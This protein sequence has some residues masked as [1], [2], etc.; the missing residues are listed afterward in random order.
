VL[1]SAPAGTGKTSLVAEWVEAA[2]HRADVTGWI[3]FEHTDTDFW[4]A[5]LECLRRLGLD[6]TAVTQGQPADAVLGTVRLTR[7]AGLVREAPHTLTIVADG[8]EMRSLEQAREVDHL[9]R[10]AAGRLRLVLVTRVDPVLPLYRYRLDE[11]LVEIRVDDLALSGEEAAGLLARFGVGL[12]EAAT[13]DLNERARGWV[14]GVRLAARTLSG[15]R[16]AEAAAA[17]FVSQTSDVNEYLLCEVLDQQ[18]PE[19]RRFLL[20]TAVPDVFSFELVEAIGGRDFV[21]TLAE[22]LRTESFMEAEPDRPGC[23]RYY[24]FFR[25]LLRAQLAYESPGRDQEVHRAVARYFAREGL[26]QQA[27]VHLATVEAWDELAPL[28]V[29]GLK[30]GTMLL[31]GT[32][33][34]LA[35]VTRKIP[36]HV[37]QR[38]A[39]LLRAALAITE[40]DPVTAGQ[41]LARA[42][43][44]SAVD[45]ARDAAV[46]VSAATLDALLACLAAPVD[47]ALEIIEEATLIL[48]SLDPHSDVPGAKELHA[49]T[50]LSCG[51][52]RLRQGALLDARRKL[53]GI[54]GSAVGDSYLTLKS[55]CLAYLALCDAWE[56]HLSP[57]T[58]A[59]AEAAAADR[60]VLLGGPSPSARVALARVA[61]EQYELTTAGRHV[62]AVGSLRG[63]LL[64]PVS[65]AVAAS[66]RAGLEGAA[67]RLPSAVA[68]LGTTADALASTDPWWS[69]SL[70]VEAASLC[71]AAGRAQEALEI[72]SRT[73]GAAGVEVS[74]ATATALVEQGQPRATEVAE[75]GAGAVAGPL[76]VRTEVSLL[77][78]QAC[79][80]LPG[81]R[82]STRAV[83]N[84]NLALRLAAPELLRR[85]FRE[86]GPTMRQF[87]SALPT[88]ARDHPWLVSSSPTT[89]ETTFPRQ[90]DS[91]P[92]NH[93]ARGGGLIEP[94]TVKELEVLGHLEELLTT[95]EIAEKM[96]ISVNTVRTHIRSIL[97]KL[98]VNRRHAA[99]RKARALGILHG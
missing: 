84:V 50:D 28:V 91:V 7:L 41:E 87:L 96:F 85:P 60:G 16:D 30:V 3:S 89:T 36:S 82:P 59:A 19:L 18:T 83:G 20:E 33:G 79:G 98:E 51:V 67:G 23:F 94:L 72:L 37:E 70:R 63:L 48:M 52:A 61:L 76:T 13:H 1:V 95:E 81:H 22:V 24:P 29:D 39:C 31:Q 77:L 6:V 15:S 34:A 58:R 75:L 5:F 40:G 17:S 25:D 46:I 12:S 26:V 93:P 4:A 80:E 2:D 10:R 9:I 54:A 53:S 66:V 88:L 35:E 11:K 42:R 55:D 57:A 69:D 90:R 45:S 71:T 65:Q 56:G 44:A 99:V 49:L 27:M 21:R 74:V 73:E 62:A 78:V 68:I 47:E 92:G 14:T 38:S 97:R 64:D 8:Y 86:V 32:D 43:E